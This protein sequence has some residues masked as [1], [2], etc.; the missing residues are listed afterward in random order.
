MFMTVDTTGTYTVSKNSINYSCSFSIEKGLAY[1]TRT[2]AD[3]NTEV[4]SGYHK[5]AII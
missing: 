1:T 3:V 5:M 2:N 4:I